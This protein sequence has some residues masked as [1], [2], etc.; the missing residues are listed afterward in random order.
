[1]QSTQSNNQKSHADMINEVINYQK[2]N[3][4]DSVARVILDR[5]MEKAMK[6]SI[7]DNSDYLSIEIS[8][9]HNTDLLKHFINHTD[10]DERE[11]VIKKLIKGL[12]DEK[13]G[14]RVKVCRNLPFQTGEWRKYNQIYAIHLSISK[15]Q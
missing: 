12:Q 11:E 15:T 4:V 6:A 9:K 8:S 1:M 3:F 10:A 13:Y 5:F 14:Y 7:N 2:N